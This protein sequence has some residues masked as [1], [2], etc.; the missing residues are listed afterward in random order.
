[1]YVCPLWWVWLGQSVENIVPS[2][3]HSSFQHQKSLPPPPPPLHRRH[4]WDNWGFD[5]TIS[6]N[7]NI[8]AEGMQKLEFKQL[9]ASLKG[10]VG[11]DLNQFGCN[12][13]NKATCA[14]GAGGWSGDFQCGREH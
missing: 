2:A 9:K 6:D 7:P 11:D 3:E 10:T 1:M 5:T 13:S 12:E 8:Q 4:V 14:V